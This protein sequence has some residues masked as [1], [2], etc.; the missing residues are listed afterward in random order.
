MPDGFY[1][2]KILLTSHETLFF[3]LFT[4]L[5]NWWYLMSWNLPWNSIKTGLVQ[6]GS[7]RTRTASDYCLVIFH[8]DDGT[9]LFIAGSE[10]QGWG[11]TCIL[12]RPK[13]KHTAGGGWDAVAASKCQVAGATWLSRR[14]REAGKPWLKYNGIMEAT[15][16]I[17]D[18]CEPVT[19][20][21][22][23]LWDRPGR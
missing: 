8:W 16:S 4:M 20:Q 9:I 14:C 7:S 21:W 17:D 1:G 10:Q 6:M 11:P 12:F 15:S 3:S 18:R 23:R 22:V 5:A 19:A 2:N 13:H